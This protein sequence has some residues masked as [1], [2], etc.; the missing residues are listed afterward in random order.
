MIGALIMAI[1]V[2][3]M[4]ATN[5]VHLGLAIMLV[6]FVFSTIGF[7]QHAEAYPYKSSPVYKFITIVIVLGVFAFGVGCLL[8]G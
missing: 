2:T 4:I 1:A 6:G 8:A 5:N 3:A 7:F